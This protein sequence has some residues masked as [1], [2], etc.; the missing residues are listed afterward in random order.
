MW[1][2]GESFIVHSSISP[3]DYKTHNSFILILS[4][5][6]VCSRMFDEYACWSD[7]QPNSTVK[8]PCP[9]YLPWY[10]QGRYQVANTHI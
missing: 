8:V 9:W 7:G 2:H 5:E 6:L 1:K 10:D 4:P 3:T